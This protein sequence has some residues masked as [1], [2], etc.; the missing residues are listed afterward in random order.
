VTE[1]W[2]TVSGLWYDYSMTEFTKIA[3]TVPT[4]IYTVIERLRRRLGKSRSAVVALALEDWVRKTDFADAD[5]RYIEG[6][7]RVPE[8][9]HEIAAVAEQATSHW[10]TWLPGAPSIAAEP[11]RA[12]DA[13]SAHAA[14]QAGPPRSAHA[15][16]SRRPPRAANAAATSGPRRSRSATSKRPRR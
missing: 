14:P 8:A 6:Y 7:L 13:R 5:R 16:P 1:R 2:S 11:S 12:A 9:V 10:D 15:A 4:A 3:V